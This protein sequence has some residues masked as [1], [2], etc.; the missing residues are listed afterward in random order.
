MK[1]F[2]TCLCCLLLG[3]HLHAQQ[4]LAAAGAYRAGTTVALSYSVGELATQTFTGA[5]V[6]LTQGFQQSDLNTT[7]LGDRLRATVSCYPN[8]ATTTVFLSAARPGV[9]LVELYD[10]QGCNLLHTAVPISTATPL[11]V[12]HLAD[13][14]YAIR[15]REASTGAAASVVF[16]KASY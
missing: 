7:R 1:P 8:P 9:Y 15:F 10:M 5:N 16:D 3:G 13:G 11:A 4:L 14:R 2:L 12:D 6:Q